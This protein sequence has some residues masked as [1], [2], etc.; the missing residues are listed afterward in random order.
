MTAPE[1]LREIEARGVSIRLESGAL[2]MRPSS[3]LDARVLAD[4]R[5]MKSQLIALVELKSAVESARRGAW[6][7]PTA[8]VL[9]A[10]RN[11]NAVIGFPLTVSG[12]PIAPEV[13]AF[14]QGFA[15]APIST[16]PTQEAVAC[17]R[18]AF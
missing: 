4:V 18:D 1:L 13:A 8:R 15:G 16:P 14:A 7:N 10:W 9:A 11:A 5:E 17:T 6:C 2:K 12:E 3:A